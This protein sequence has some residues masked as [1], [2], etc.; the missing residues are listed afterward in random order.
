MGTYS[1]TVTINA[2]QSIHMKL[3]FDW[4]QRIWLGSQARQNRYENIA[5]KYIQKLTIHDKS[6]QMSLVPFL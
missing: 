1:V 4:Y 3:H 2:T 6:Y 5:E